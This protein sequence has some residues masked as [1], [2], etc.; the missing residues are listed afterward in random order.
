[1]RHK[2]HIVVELTGKLF[3]PGVSLLFYKH[4]SLLTGRVASTDNIGCHLR[5]IGRRFSKDCFDGNDT[6]AHC[7]EQGNTL[8]RSVLVS[9]AL[10]G[11][12]GVALSRKVCQLVDQDAAIGRSPAISLH[13]VDMRFD[14]S[15]GQNATALLGVEGRVYQSPSVSVRS[16]TVFRRA[17]ASMHGMV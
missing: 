11:M 12:V 2:N 13:A 3:D 6:L 16:S 9:L 15:N 14:L 4:P 10:T 1:M 8:V 17:S 7:L 5:D